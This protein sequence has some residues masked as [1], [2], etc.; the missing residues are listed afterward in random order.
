[1]ELHTHK[2]SS[3]A[4]RI[5][6]IGRHFVDEGLPNPCATEVVKCALSGAHRLYA[7]KAEQLHLP[8]VRRV[9]AADR[10]T[11]IRML[12]ATDRDTNRMRRLRDRALL[13]IGM[14]GAFRRSELVALHAADIEPGP[15]GLVTIIRRSQHNRSAQQE[16]LVRYGG[17]VCPVRALQDW[18]HA[19]GISDGPVFRPV[20]RHG[21][22]AISALSATAVGEVVKRLAKAAGLNP[23]EFAGHSLRAGCVTQAAIDGVSLPQIMAHSRHKTPECVST[24]VRMGRRFD[25]PALSLWGN[26]S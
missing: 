26:D 17:D 12:C 21:N 15:E 7:E 11:L 2:P 14:A 1:M 9:K 24:C 10:D 18:L 22:V 23:K 6:G 20:D 19:A 16:V 4:R 25:N 5:T 8:I 3:I 13:L